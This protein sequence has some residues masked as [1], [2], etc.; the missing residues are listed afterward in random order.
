MLNTPNQPTLESSSGLKIQLDALVSKAHCDVQ[1]DFCDITRKVPHGWEY[2]A[3]D[4][5]EHLQAVA[6]ILILHGFSAEVVTAGY[7]HDN[8]ED[9]PKLWSYQRIAQEYTEHVAKLVDWVTQQDKSLSWEERNEQYELR[10]ACA[11]D[12]ARA[13]SCADKI[14]N[15]SDTI[16]YLRLGIP[17]KDLLKRGWQA[18]SQKLHKMLSIYHGHV[19]EQMYSQF[20]TLLETFDLLARPLEQ[21]T[22]RTDFTQ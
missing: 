22:E 5:V 9:L 3:Q 17:L 16:P 11:P 12:E 10:L 6:H 4:Y 14:S 18:N 1:R 7:L 8:L 21:D 2:P 13:I 20:C 15:L 19:P